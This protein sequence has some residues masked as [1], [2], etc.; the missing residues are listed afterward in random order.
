MELPFGDDEFLDYYET[1]IEEDNPGHKIQEVIEEELPKQLQKLYSDEKNL[2][3]ALWKY[4]D[5]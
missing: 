1:W 5:D 4:T 2:D 3:K